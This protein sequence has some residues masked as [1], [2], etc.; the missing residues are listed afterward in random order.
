MTYDSVTECCTMSDGVAVC[1]KSLTAS[2]NVVQCLAVLLCAVRRCL[3]VILSVVQCLLL[4]V[5][6]CL[7][8]SL[9]LT[10][11]V[12]KRVTVSVLYGV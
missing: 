11:A 2:L 6:R 12:V 4:C 7:T 9:L 3:T 10:A 1:C 8:V 5:V